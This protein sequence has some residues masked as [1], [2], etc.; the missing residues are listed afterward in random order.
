M[1]AAP[2]RTPP[3]VCAAACSAPG[4]RCR[5]AAP[6][7]EVAHRTASPTCAADAPVPKSIDLVLAQPGL[8]V[9]I[10]L[11]AAPSADGTSFGT[12]AFSDVDNALK[13]SANPNANLR[14]GSV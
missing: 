10:P 14:D 5:P 6:R 12:L 9:V 11:T 3:L 8:P 13:A 1:H 4:T 2:G 7:L